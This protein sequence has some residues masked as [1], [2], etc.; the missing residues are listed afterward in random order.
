MFYFVSVKRRV[1]VNDS[2]IAVLAAWQQRIL[3]IN[4][5]RAVHLFNLLANFTSSSVNV[6]FSLVDMHFSR[7]IHEQSSSC[8]A[9]IDFR[10]LRLNSA[11]LVLLTLRNFSR[12]IYIYMRA[13]SRFARSRVLW[14]SLIFFFHCTQ[15]SSEELVGTMSC[16]V[17][18]S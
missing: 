11:V 16:E 5:V 18:R 6:Y 3:H 9:N 14:R 1:M 17:R 12:I 10:S 13:L 2:C 7:Y 4:R 15:S 8:G